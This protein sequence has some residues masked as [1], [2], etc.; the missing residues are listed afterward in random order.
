MLRDFDILE[1][2]ADELCT[3]VGDKDSTRWLFAVLEVPSRLWAGSVLGRRSARNTNTVINDV[4]VRGRLVGV[5]LIATD[6]FEDYFGAIEHLIGP[7]C[8]YGQVLKTRRN[9]RVIRV[10]RRVKIG[11]LSGFPNP[12]LLMQCLEFNDKHGLRSHC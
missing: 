12:C 4:I 5:P 8:V 7:A 10:D 3:F 1:L 2:Q 6:G 11:G 9:N